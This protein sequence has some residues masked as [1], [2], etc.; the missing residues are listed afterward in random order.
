[1]PLTKRHPSKGERKNL[2]KKGVVPSEKK[3]YN[4]NNVKRKFTKEEYDE[5]YGISEE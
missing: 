3:H 1:M 4:N 2:F 5:I